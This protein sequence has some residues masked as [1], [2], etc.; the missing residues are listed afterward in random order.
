MRLVPCSMSHENFVSMLEDLLARV[1]EGDS[2]EGSLEYAIPED[3][4]APARSF[5]VRASYRV[6]NLQ[7]QGGMRMHGAWEE[8]PAGEAR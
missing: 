1:R 7:G 3:E 8:V 2:F 4:D 6:G 5:S